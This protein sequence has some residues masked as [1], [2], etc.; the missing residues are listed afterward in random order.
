MVRGQNAVK[1]RSSSDTEGEVQ[2]VLGKLEAGG[3]D[4]KIMRLMA[5]S[6][7]AF[8]PFLLMSISLMER[9]SLPPSDREVAIL[10][11]ATLLGVEYEWREHIPLSDRAG[12]TEEQRAGIQ[13]G[14]IEDEKL[15]T[16]PMRLAMRIATVARQQ[17][18]L[19]TQDWDEACATWGKEGALDLVLTIGWWGGFVP[20]VINCLGITNPTGPDD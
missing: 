2:R 19:P 8:R 11:L 18:E 13:A 7:N 12:I 6:P 5:N 20:T 15:F 14:N 17:N 16:A 10:R 4:I 1:P 3:N 9:A